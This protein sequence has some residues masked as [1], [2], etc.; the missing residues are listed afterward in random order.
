MGSLHLGEVAS[1]SVR[2]VFNK[3]STVQGLKYFRVLCSFL[4]HSF[5]L[6][7]LFSL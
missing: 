5:L 4:T 7:Q 1:D 6:F 3:S 2:S